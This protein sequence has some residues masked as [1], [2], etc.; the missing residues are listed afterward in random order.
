M[1]RLKVKSDLLKC[2]CFARLNKDRTLNVCI[3]AI[4]VWSLGQS[5]SALP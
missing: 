2:C 3:P 1:Y 4:C 5:K